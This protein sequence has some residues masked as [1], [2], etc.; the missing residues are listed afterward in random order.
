MSEMIESTADLGSEGTEQIDA[1][2]APK[3]PEYFVGEYTQDD[4]S[5]YL[6]QVKEL[7]SRLRELESGFRGAVSPLEAKLTEMQSKFG[8]QPVFEPKFEKTLAKLT[9]YDPRL[10]ELLKDALAEDMRSSFAINP[11]D[12]TALEPHVGPMLQE[13]QSQLSNE[14]ANTVLRTLPFDVNGV[15]NRD[16][17]GKALP[18]TTDLQKGF[19]QYWDQ[20]PLRVQEALTTPGLGFA[21]AM[22]E[23]SKWYAARTKG[24]GAA[25]GEASARLASGRQPGKGLR[26]VPAGPKD[27]SQAFEQGVERVRREMQ[28]FQKRA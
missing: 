4:V 3:T 12:R 19:Q 17:F 24:Q 6:G 27:E 16:E 25:A 5:S 23:F 13:L 18:P 20:A 14:L 21:Q 2:E 7:P 8:T 22:T 10:G 15:V 1:P 26:A 9:E 11:L 28:Q